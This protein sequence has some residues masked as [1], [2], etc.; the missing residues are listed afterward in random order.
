M[1]SYEGMDFTKVV[2]RDGD[3]S[4]GGLSSGGLLLGWPFIWVVSSG[5]LIRWPF[6]RV[7]FNR[8][9]HQMV[10]QEGRL[11]L[12]WSSSGGSSSGGSHQANLSLG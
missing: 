9:S 8:W 1:Y 4:S 7:V 5:G 6:I 11:L 12:G 3:F 10:F 2:S